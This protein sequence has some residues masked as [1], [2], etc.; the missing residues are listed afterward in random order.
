MMGGSSGPGGMMMQP[1]PHSGQAGP[2]QQVNPFPFYGHDP[3]ENSKS[4]P[5]FG[6]NCHCKE[7]IGLYDLRVECP[8]HYG[9]V[10]QWCVLCRC[11]P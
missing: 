8:L 1:G 3:S 11:F 7:M 6:E 9:S 10:W 2:D 4:D 5:L